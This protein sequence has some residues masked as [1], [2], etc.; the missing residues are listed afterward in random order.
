[1]TSIFALV[2]A[3][4][5]KAALQRGEVSRDRLIALREAIDEIAARYTDISFIS[6]ADSLLLKSNWSVGQFD[7]QVRYTYEPE[8]FVRL[9]AELQETYRSVLGLD[10]YAVLTQGS[11]EYYDDALLHISATHNH[12]S[13]N[14]LGLPFAQLLAID[15]AARDAI[16]SGRHLPGEL[17]MDE[18]LFR[19]LGFDHHFQSDACPRGSYRA[20]M[21]TGDSSYYIASCRQ[22]LENL[23]DVPPLR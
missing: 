5:I 6:F 14:S 4:G 8:T 9:I 19:S 22:I 12:V 21:M 17:Y 7:S 1:V 16:H 23:R 18:D 15:Y 3:I 13:L 20:P 2:D 11:N 10:L